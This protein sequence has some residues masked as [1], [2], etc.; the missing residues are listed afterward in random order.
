MKDRLLLL[1]AATGSCAAAWT[2]WHYLG[3]EALD[4]LLMLALVSVAAENRRLRR[5][6]R[7]QST[8]S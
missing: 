1:A 6:L 8:T 5:M 4:V 7:Q 3:R 2:I